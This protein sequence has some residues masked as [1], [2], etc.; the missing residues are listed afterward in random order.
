MEKNKELSF[1]EAL[2]QLESS[3]EK[4]KKDGITLEDAM[5]SYEEGLKYYKQ[6][7]EILNDAKQ[8]IEIISN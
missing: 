1:E 6:C 2:K 4:L 8:K 3:A 5:K 7:S